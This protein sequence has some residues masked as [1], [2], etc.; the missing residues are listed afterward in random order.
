MVER[1]EDR[2]R[3]DLVGG[4]EAKTKKKREEA[5]RGQARFGPSP[6]PSEPFENTFSVLYLVFSESQVS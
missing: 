1:I 4:K 3:W 5:V 6:F 2:K